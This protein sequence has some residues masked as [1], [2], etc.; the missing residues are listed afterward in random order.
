MSRGGE[1][2]PSGPSPG[3][4]G[5]AAAPAAGAVPEAPLRFWD[6]YQDPRRAEADWDRG[7]AELAARHPL[8]EQD[9][10]PDLPGIRAR[11]RR[12]LRWKALRYLVAHDE[13]R[14]L[15]RYVFRHP[16]RHGWGLIRSYLRRRRYLREGDFWL[17]GVS[18]QA[19]LERLLARPDTRF[20]VGFSYCHKPFEC[21]S[22]RFSDA[23]RADPGHPVCRQ[24]FI[25]KCVNALDAERG[26]PL[27]IPTVHYIG[28]QVLALQSDGHP[29]PTVFM[30]TACELTLEMF[31]DWGNM[32]DIVCAGVRLD[33]VIC[34]TMRAFEASERGIKPG[35]TMVREQTARRMLELI[36][37]HRLADDAG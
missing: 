37:L 14:V 13:R 25:G 33:G 22:G 1:G 16:L 34:N 26:K 18:G 7:A 12:L 32:T 11:T 8:R 2:G 10:R 17:L 24:C 21:P 4:R 28:E 27:F 3:R 30:I 15:Q 20:V 29:G 9:P 35:L 5:G 19:E 31:A 36:R 23:C 6:R